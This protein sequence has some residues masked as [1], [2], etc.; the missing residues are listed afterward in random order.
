VTTL[1]HVAT[2]ASSRL[3]ASRATWDSALHYTRATCVSSAA[4]AASHAAFS[5][6]SPATAPRARSPACSAARARSSSAPRSV[7]HAARAS[8][9]AL[10]AAAAAAAR[11]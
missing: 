6:S 3:G 9:A 10:P 8:S 11:S 7:S 2:L 4:R 1:L 5:F